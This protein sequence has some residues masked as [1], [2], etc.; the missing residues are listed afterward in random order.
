MIRRQP[1][2]TLFPYTTLFRSKTPMHT[3]INQMLYPDRQA[4]FEKLALSF[5]PQP[6]IKIGPAPMPSGEHNQGLLVRR[7]AL[8][9]P[10]LPSRQHTPCSY[11]QSHQLKTQYDY[12]T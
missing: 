10:R 9:P 6:P 2:S 12:H 4:F 7:N 5:P 8:P 11:Q 1:K 3:S